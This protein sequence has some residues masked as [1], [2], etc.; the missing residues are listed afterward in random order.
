VFGQWEGMVWLEVLEKDR[1][2][3]KKEIIKRN[4]TEDR[5]KRRWR[6]KRWKMEQ[7]HV[8]LRSHK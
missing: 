2:G 4:D 1:E 3:R 5:R 6:K 8:A 7:K